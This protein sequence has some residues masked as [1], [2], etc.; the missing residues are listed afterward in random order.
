MK[1]LLF[2]MAIVTKVVMGFI[3]EIGMDG[4]CYSGQVPHAGFDCSLLLL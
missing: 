4:G 2:A 3:P 1:D